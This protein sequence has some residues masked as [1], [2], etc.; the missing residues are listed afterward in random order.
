MKFFW[1]S[2]S[3][4]TKN[5]HHSQNSTE[6]TPRMPLSRKGPS[7][8]PPPVPRPASRTHSQAE[9]E[10]NRRLLALAKQELLFLKAEMSAQDFKKKHDAV[11]NYIRLKSI[12]QQWIN[13]TYDSIARKQQYS[14][15]I[16]ARAQCFSEG[17]SP[18]DQWLLQRKDPDAIEWK[19]D[20]IIYANG[21][22][23]EESYSPP[24]SPPTPLPQ[25]ENEE[26]WAVPRRKKNKKKKMSVEAKAAQQ[27][28]LREK[29]EIANEKKVRKKAVDEHRARQGV[30]RMVEARISRNMDK[31][32]EKTTISP[33]QAGKRP[34]FPAHGM[35]Q[36]VEHLNR[37]D[38]Y[39]ILPNPQDHYIES[40]IK[41]NDGPTMTSE[42]ALA[43]AI[44]IWYSGG[45]TNQST[46]Y[47]EFW[48]HSKI[49]E[50]KK[51]GFLGEFGKLIKNSIKDY[52]DGKKVSFSSKTPFKMDRTLKENLEKMFFQYSKKYPTNPEA[53]PFI[54]HVTYS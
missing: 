15:K 32:V 39:M 47:S 31:S 53:K 45:F 29:V 21:I 9:S 22:L 1:K 26:V 28:A 12:A 34:T 54:M 16:H 3:N 6:S 4:N 42:V 27:K 20:F 7:T 5:E 38:D 44:E 8:P 17:V 30:A 52:E 18:D 35:N 24:I 51:Q 50:Y 46:P 11:L 36:V 2:I 49:Q 40:P 37:Y 14:L 43:N 10:N 25:D 23:A 41:T 48:N 33:V 13:N 19:E